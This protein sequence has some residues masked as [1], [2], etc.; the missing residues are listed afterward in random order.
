M[1]FAANFTAIDFETANFRRDS[2]CQFAAVRIRDGQIADTAMWMIRPQPMYF[3]KSNIRIHGITPKDVADEPQFGQLWQAI[4]SFLGNDCLVAHNAGFDIGVLIACLKKH[5]KPVPELSYTCTRA[6]ARRT[7]PGRQRYGLKPLATWL[8]IRFQHHDALEDSIAC[9]K[10]MLAAGIDKKV[11]T[12]EDLEKKLRLSR[13]HANAFQ[14]NGPGRSS[15]RKPSKP[16]TRSVDKRN[17]I[18]QLRLPIEQDSDKP[19]RLATITPPITET[20]S[21]EPVDF[22]RLLIRADFIRPLAG[23]T[24]F[25][26]GKLQILDA[27][28]ARL[29]ASRSGANYQSS[30]DSSTNL[31]VLGD[32][33]CVPANSASQHHSSVAEY[34][35]RGSGKLKVMTESQFLRMV[36]S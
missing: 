27:E 19:S 18:L 21:T 29:L 33:E 10:I 14:T 4:Q 6:V 32:E 23:K 16:V 25:F 7:W 5:R 17:R 8:G 9:A 36:S 20:P 1:E 26:S 34:L 3:A 22:H 13:G 30:V 35:Q 12:L 28:K 31:I 15:R 24:V 11:C 2:A